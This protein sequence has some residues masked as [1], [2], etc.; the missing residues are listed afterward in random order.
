MPQSL[1]TPKTPYHANGKFER[2]IYRPLINQSINQF[3]AVFVQSMFQD[4][5]I[6]DFVDK[7]NNDVVF[8]NSQAVEM[9]SHSKSQVLF[10]L[11]SSLSL[12]HHG[13]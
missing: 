12:S 13:W 3:N 6:L 1:I 10:R 11:S 2:V 4:L 8:L 5:L 9:F 7:V